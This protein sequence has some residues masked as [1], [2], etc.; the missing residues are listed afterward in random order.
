MVLQE[1]FLWANQRIVFGK[2]L[3]EQ[4]VIRYKLAQM[5]GA[6][7]ALEGYLESITYQMQ[8]MDQL[9]QAIELGGAIAILKYQVPDER[10]F[11]AVSTP[12][13]R[14]FNAD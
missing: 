13:Q 14:C 11:N 8:R 5:I 4:P 1:C 12:F 9:A 2:K 6:V 10:C 7:E 3:V